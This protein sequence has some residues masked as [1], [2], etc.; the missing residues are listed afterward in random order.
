M[1]FYLITH[2]KLSDLAGMLSV[3]EY[4]TTNKLMTKSKTTHIH[5]IYAS[6]QSTVYIYM[7]VYCNYLHRLQ[8]QLLGTLN[9]TM[10]LLIF[11]NDFLLPRNKMSYNFI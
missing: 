7:I 3:S 9:F 10:S 5:D 1:Q 8:H 4:F 11:L 6:F 2:N